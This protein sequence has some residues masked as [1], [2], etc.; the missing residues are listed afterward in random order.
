MDGYHKHEK[1]GEFVTYARLRA[2]GNNGFQE[3]AT[4]I[5][6]AADSGGSSGSGTTTGAQPGMVVGGPAIEGSP[7]EGTRPAGRSQR[8]RRTGSGRRRRTDR[9]HQASLRRRQVQHQGRQG[10]L[11]SFRM[12]RPAGS[13][14][15]GAEGQVQ[16]PDQQRPHQPRLAIGLSRPGERLRHGSLALPV[17]PDEPA[18][19]G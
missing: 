4:G 7:R 15:A 8:G 18:G 2:M 12:A 17:H 16:V 3:P 9:R 10:H 11:Q 1:G 5:E 14:Q 6:G 13:R 19:Y